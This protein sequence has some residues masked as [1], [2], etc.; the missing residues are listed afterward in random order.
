M[1]TR[2]E[3]IVATVKTLLIAVALIAATRAV[4]G[5]PLVLAQ[6]PEALCGNG[7]DVCDTWTWCDGPYCVVV[8]TYFPVNP[9]P[10]PGG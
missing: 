7:Y 3:I 5:P 1:K 10:M 8:Y 4:V 2:L 6:T 9:L